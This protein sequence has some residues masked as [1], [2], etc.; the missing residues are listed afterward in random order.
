MEQKR[1]RPIRDLLAP[2]PLIITC[3]ESAVTVFFHSMREIYSFENFGTKY[4]SP[5]HV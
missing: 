2:M 4:F 5:L 3:I 1:H